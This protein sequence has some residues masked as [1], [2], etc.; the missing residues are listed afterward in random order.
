MAAP[1][2]FPE[3]EVMRFDDILTGLVALVKVYGIGGV[4]SMSV[5]FDGVVLELEARIGSAETG[6]SYLLG[7]IVVVFAVLTSGAV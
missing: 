6:C 2:G 1:D 3:T 7:E 4:V 5:I